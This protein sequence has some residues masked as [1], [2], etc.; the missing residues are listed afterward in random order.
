MRRH[1][2]KFKVG[3]EPSQMFRLPLRSGLCD[4]PHLPSPQVFKLGHEAKS[5]PAKPLPC[6][7]ILF[8]LS[9]PWVRRS[10]SYTQR[11]WLSAVKTLCH[12]RTLGLDSLRYAACQTVEAI[13]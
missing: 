3:L 1:T 10:S 2:E 9:T 8:L 6:T 7:C 12:H 4:L 11:G 5:L 13:G